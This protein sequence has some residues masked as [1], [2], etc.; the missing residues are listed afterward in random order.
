M[1]IEYTEDHK[2]QFSLQDVLE[3]L[4]DDR[5]VA[6]IEALSCED[7][8]IKH[9]MDQVLDSCTENG[10]HGGRSSGN[11]TPFTPIDIARRRIAESSSKVAAEEIAALK[12]AVESAKELGDE[13]W[14]RYHDECRRHQRGYPRASD[15]GF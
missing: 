14:R 2:F 8:I 10:W 6:L 5:K 12:R 15:A 1:S 9:I 3:K 7:A 13:G 11:V 4:P